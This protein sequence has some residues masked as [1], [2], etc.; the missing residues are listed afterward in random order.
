MSD[1]FHRLAKTLRR[2]SGR[3][4]APPQVD[5]RRAP[6]FICSKPVLW[7]LGREQGEG[8]LREISQT[9]L[10]LLCAR[11]LL[12]GKHLRLRPVADTEATTLSLDVVIATVVYSRPKAGRYEIGLELVNPDRISRFA[13]IGELVSGGVQAPGVESG[14]G[15]PNSLPTLRL[16]PPERLSAGPDRGLI[17]SE[18][19]HRLGIQE[20]EKNS[21]K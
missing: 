2:L 5:R 13:W 1:L 9:G 8:E 15:R 3:P 7:E 10:K 16:L 14:S 21:K 4:E 6:R 18:F 12:A 19:L 11:P 17:R 20:E